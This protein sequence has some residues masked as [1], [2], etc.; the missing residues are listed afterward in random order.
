MA[1]SRTRSWSGSDF[2]HLPLEF[3]P[4]G[5]SKPAAELGHIWREA[6]VSAEVPVLSDCK[7]FE[8]GPSY[9]LGEGATCRLIHLR[10][11]PRVSDAASGE[12]FGKN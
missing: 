2:A 8:L 9:M 5:R 4:P 10:L 11:S 3:L 6:T 12:R 1:P 7:F